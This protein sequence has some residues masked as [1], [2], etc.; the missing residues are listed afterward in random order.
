MDELPPPPPPEVPPPELPCELTDAPP[1]EVLTR[2]FMALNALF[3][4]S[5]CCAPA[6]PVALNVP[7][8]FITL[9]FI[10]WNVLIACVARS[11]PLHKSIKFL[12]SPSVVRV[13]LFNF[14]T[15]SKARACELTP[16]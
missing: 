15:A 16:D 3:K 12:I 11:S 1:T 9:F 13:G 7:S 5:D 6:V 8:G 2:L 10:L 14:F 4:A